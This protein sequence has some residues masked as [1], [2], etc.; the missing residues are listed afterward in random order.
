MKYEFTKEELHQIE[1]I[2]AK[3]PEVKPATLPVLWLA[4]NKYGH[5][6]PEVQKLV[7]KTLGLPEAHVHGVAEFYT[8]YYKEEKGK[9]VLDVCTCL[10]CQLC[11]G[12]DVLH[13]LEEKLGIQSG[14]TTDDG[15]FSLQQVECLGACGYAPMMQISNERYVNHLTPEKID[16]VIEGLRDNTLPE[17][18]SNKMPQHQTEEN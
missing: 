15:M 9:Y 10:S 8:Q 5:V 11:G 13:Y 12:Y 18:E 17:F 7:A 1:R 14:E 2:K 4:Q 16:A 6:K 3:F